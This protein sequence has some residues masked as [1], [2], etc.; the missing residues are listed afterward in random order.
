MGYFRGS[1]QDSEC[2]MHLE[3]QLLGKISIQFQEFE[4]FK[5]SLDDIAKTACLKKMN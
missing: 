4:I 5:A 2:A 3:Y 1:H